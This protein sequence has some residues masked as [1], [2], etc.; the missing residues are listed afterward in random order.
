MSGSIGDLEFTAL[1]SSALDRIQEFFL[2]SHCNVLWGLLPIM[3]APKKKS[4]PVPP[5]LTALRVNT[6]ETN[7]SWIEHGFLWTTLAV[8]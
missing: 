7:S 5:G 3:I 1:L 4:K 8:G 2:N 6:A